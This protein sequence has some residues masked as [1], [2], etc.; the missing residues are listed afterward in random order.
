M[1]TKSRKA[2]R[3]GSSKQLI[4][5]IRQKRPDLIQATIE[6]PLR[7]VVGKN[8][9]RIRGEKGLTRQALAECTAD[10]GPRTIQRIEEAGEDSNPTLR[11]LEELARALEV[12]VQA[13]TDPQGT[14]MGQRWRE[15]A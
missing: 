4:Q 9:L 7:V 1:K 15:E 14:L 6:Q 5:L 12:K 3:F 11:V 10:V 8:L 2:V 13:L